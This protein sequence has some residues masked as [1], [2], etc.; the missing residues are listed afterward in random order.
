MVDIS[1]VVGVSV[2]IYGVSVDVE[3]QKNLKMPKE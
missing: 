1:T 3:L 2:D